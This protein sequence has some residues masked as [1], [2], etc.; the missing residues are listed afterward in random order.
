MTAV[1][2]AERAVRTWLTGAAGLLIVAAAFVMMAW[3]APSPLHARP[4]HQPVTSTSVTA[5]LESQVRAGTKGSPW[6]P[7]ARTLIED[8]P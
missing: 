3:A 6:S 2:S 4:R 5:Q 7:A 8:R 1:V